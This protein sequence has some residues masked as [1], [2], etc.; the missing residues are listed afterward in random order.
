MFRVQATDA[1]ILVWRQ[2]EAP[3]PATGTARPE[4]RFDVLA[5][6]VFVWG[7]RRPT[8]AAPPSS[9]VPVFVHHYRQQGIM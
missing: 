3:A 8:T 1:S 9:A 4:R 5:G 6:G 2:G 7:R